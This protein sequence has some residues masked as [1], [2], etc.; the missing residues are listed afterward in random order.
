[1]KKVQYDPLGTIWQRVKA[2]LWFS[3]FHLLVIISENYLAQLPHLHFWFPYH[4]GV[5]SF[6][7]IFLATDLPVVNFWRTAGAADYFCGDDPG[8]VRSYAISSPF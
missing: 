4:L 5:F 1:M 6:P 8:T 2:L 3:L 7:F